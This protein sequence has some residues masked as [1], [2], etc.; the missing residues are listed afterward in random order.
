MG[1]GMKSRQVF[2]FYHAIILILIVSCYS[3]TFQSPPV[4]DD[5]HA[6]VRNPIVHVKEF[7]AEVLKN[8]ANSHFGLA[9]F[10]PMLTFGLDYLLGKGK[11]YVF[12]ATNLILHI[13]CFLACFWVI[14]GFYLLALSQEG[15]SQ[16][17]NLL[18]LA[19][20]ALWALHPVQTSAVTYLVQRMASIQALFFMLSS[21][22]F[23][24]GRLNS[25]AGKKVKSYV[26]Y[27]VCLITALA[28][29]VSK[30]NSATLPLI[31]FTIELYFFQPDFPKHVKLFLAQVYRRPKN[32]MLSLFALA[33]LSYVAVEAVIYFSS[34]YSGRH[35]TMGQR[36]LTEARVIVQYICAILVPDPRALSI[37]HDVPLS[38]SLISPPTTLVGVFTIGILL[39]AIVLTFRRYRLVSFGLLWFL[40]NLA[41]ESTIVP[42]ELK[43]DHR[44]YLPS[45]GLILSAVET[46]RHVLSRCI[47]KYSPPQKYRLSMA[48][49]GLCCAILSLLTFSRN[50]T[51]QDLITINEDAIKKAPNNPRAHANYAVALARAG[52]VDEARAEAYKAIELGREGFE[53]HIVATTAIVTSYMQQDQWEKAI[54]LGESLLASRPNKF[55]AMSLP[56]LYL[57][58]AEC[59]RVKKDIPGSFRYIFE[60]FKTIQKFPA[61]ASNKHW[62]H[63]EL[64]AVLRDIRNENISHEELLR[65]VN[66][67][68]SLCRNS[69]T[70]E[71]WAICQ[72]FY[73]EDYESARLF[74]SRYPQGSYSEHILW[75]IYLHETRS[76]SQSR[77]WSMVQRYLERPF[78]VSKLSLVGAYVI[79][80]NQR[81]NLVK[82]LGYF[83]LRVAGWQDPLNAD[84]P[85]LQGWYAFQDGHTEEA[86]SKARQAIELAPQS[87]R[88]WIAMGFFEERA[89]RLENALTA[90]R[91][92][93]ELYPG[94]P[95]RHILKNLVAQLETQIDVEPPRVSNMAQAVL[96]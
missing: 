74:A 79:Q 62:V 93:L 9:R 77:E 5:F 44:M 46:I 33:L 48:T 23:V 1:V 22:A 88:A 81:L 61:L 14:R 53:D 8:L 50:E 21:A 32:W 29:F 10:L 69:K 96:L 90:F 73:L 36:M 70:I 67:E 2:Y 51:W 25:A 71:E 24:Q 82:S 28:S 85:L 52:R 27:S 72:L 66:G 7:N 59:Y 45:V 43:F 42:L 6:F 34:G 83:L 89:G 95:K 92:T 91:H 80:K 4:L 26:Y 35:F 15:S 65:L 60:A 13:F 31:I 49:I 55:D 41:V 18:P 86:V 57:K 47:Q 75:L 76:Q 68:T 39:W 56:I 94:Y 16:Q 63:R 11:L 87:A 20:S 84:V 12:H 64:D 40:I 19:V 30:E 37:E 58:I 38:T 3:N 17:D 78:S 54:E